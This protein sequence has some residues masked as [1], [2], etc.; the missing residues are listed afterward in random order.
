M[1]EAEAR[2][3][4]L[5]TERDAIRDTAVSHQV[6]L[7]HD[8]IVVRERKASDKVHVSS[9]RAGF[10]TATEKHD[11]DLGLQTC[12][13]ELSDTNQD[14]FVIGHDNDDRPEDSQLAD[15]TMVNKFGSGKAMAALYHAI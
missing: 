13:D 4:S 2:A 1:A 8:E 10:V 9:R 15:H 3:E 6:P 11:F 5:P 7:E 12:S 14:V